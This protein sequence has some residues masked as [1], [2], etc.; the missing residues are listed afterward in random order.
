M[1]KQNAQEKKNVSLF[2]YTF[3]F[4]CLNAVITTMDYLIV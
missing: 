1:E 4:K 3:S 2:D